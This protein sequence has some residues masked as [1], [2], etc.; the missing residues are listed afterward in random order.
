MM[1]QRLTNH[2]YHSLPQIGSSQLREMRKTPLHYYTAVLDPNRPHEEPTPSMK[3]G[4]AIHERLLEPESKNF[5]FVDRRT[6][7]GKESFEAILAE[8]P[9]AEALPL[10]EEPVVYGASQAVLASATVQSLHLLDGEKEGVAFATI[11]GLECKAKP[12]VWIS[13]CERYPQGLLV[14]LKTT[15]DASPEGFRRSSEEYG[16]HIQL[17]FYRM[18]LQR[19]LG[20]SDAPPAVIIAV[21]KKY[22]FMVN[23]FPVSDEAL[24]VGEEEALRLL[25]K[26][27]KCTTANHWPGYD[28]SMQPLTLSSWYKPALLDNISQLESELDEFKGR[29][30]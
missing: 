26:V 30:R 14:D 3:V 11:G 10:S 9:F 7:A 5:V 18:V 20:L 28:E 1:L 13:P 17:A 15:T 23:I 16:Y 24:R 12:D 8:N 19:A 29:E 21:E 25:E 27:R 6:K 4:S 2:E 22:P